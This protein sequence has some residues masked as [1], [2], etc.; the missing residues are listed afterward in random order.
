MPGSYRQ[1]E[2][3]KLEITVK[4]LREAISFFKS[5]SSK[6]EPEIF[7][8][9]ID[10]GYALESSIYVIVPHKGYHLDK[11]GA[12]YHI[13]RLQEFPNLLKIICGPRA[14]YVLILEYGSEA[15]LGEF[16]PVYR[17][18]KQGQQLVGLRFTYEGTPDVFFM[19][20]GT[21]YPAKHYLKRSLDNAFEHM[22][23]LIIESVRR[24]VRRS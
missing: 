20:P 11:S 16:P 13:F 18:T 24:L 5:L 15:M 17:T 8:G 4:G 19:R 2:V 1:E 14:P 22:K 10:A 21:S 3:M 6:L 12:D 23:E 7:S 9:M